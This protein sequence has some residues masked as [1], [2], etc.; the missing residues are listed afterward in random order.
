M[1]VSFATYYKWR[2]KFGD[3]DTSLMACMGELITGSRRHNQLYDEE[4][5]KKA[6]IL[7]RSPV[8]IKT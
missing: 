2:P 4:M 1:G 3:T 5:I 8:L 6:D 7:T